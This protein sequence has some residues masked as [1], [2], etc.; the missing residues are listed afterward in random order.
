[1]FREP[2][3]V[4]RGLLVAMVE[5]GESGAEKN[6]LVYENGRVVALCFYR[7]NPTKPCLVISEVI[8]LKIV[9]RMKTDVPSARQTKRPLNVRIAE[10]V[11]PHS[12]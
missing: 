2:K 5:V 1:M 11:G 6:D 3:T 8:Y 10:P 9:G 12:G 4:I 7:F